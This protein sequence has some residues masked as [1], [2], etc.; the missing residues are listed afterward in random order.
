MNLLK[1][2][3]RLIGLLG[4][5]FILSANVLVAETQPD[6]RP[7][8][9]IIILMDDISLDWIQA[10]GGA[11]PT[12]HFNQF[13]REG[14]R[15]A[16]TWCMPLCTPTRVQ[17]LT[18]QYPFRTG[19]IRH[20]DAPRWGGAGLSPDKF[21]TIAQLMRGAGYATAVAGKWQVND[22]RL[23]PQ[24]MSKHGFDE[25]S[26]WTGVES[27]NPVSEKRYWGAYIEQNGLRRAYD[28]QFG[29]DVTQNF[30]LDFIARHKDEPFFIYYP[31][32]PTHAP[33]EPTPLNRDDP[34]E[35][36]DALFAGMVTYADKQVGELLRAL[37][38]LGLRENTI[39]YLAGDNGSSTGGVRHG[40]QMPVGK[41]K[42]SDLGV[43]VP[44]IIRAPG[45]TQPG[46][47]CTALTDFTDILPT[48]L[49][50]AGL[51]LPAERTLDGHSLVPLLRG[52]DA[53]DNQRQ[54]IYS[55]YGANRI[56]R[57][58]RYL[59]TSDGRLY[60]LDTDPLQKQDI[61]DD[62]APAIVAAREKLQAD[63][64]ALPAD[65]PVPFPEF[66]DAE[67]LMRDTLRRNRNLQGAQKFE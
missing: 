33:N 35:G 60:D 29:P 8:N 62:P 38:D 21:L 24:V 10:Y 31:M 54:W 53:P 11:A 50:F 40:R 23:D 25:Y 34:P 51:P 18:G 47:V 27:N 42:L 2:P 17:L 59:Y 5:T 16:I 28:G 58:Q 14:T 64:A 22:L 13:A 49:D 57:D 66:A 48:I 44:L 19:W 63:L 55:Q 6:Q 56:I 67:Q 43:H 45:V 37:D 32:I 4:A 46:A 61:A 9:Q 36:E 39:V 7:P 52:D 20:Y 1:A 26:L 65:G 41:G 12:P 15:F 30:V 3:L